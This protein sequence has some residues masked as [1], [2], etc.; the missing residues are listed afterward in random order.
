MLMY[1]RRQIFQA[2]MPGSAVINYKKNFVAKG[3]YTSY[4]IVQHQYKSYPIS[5]GVTGLNIFGPNSFF[6]I[7][8][9]LDIQDIC[10]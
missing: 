4:P 2:F 7:V 5:P 10:I 9:F 8:Q 6:P 1:E 3:V